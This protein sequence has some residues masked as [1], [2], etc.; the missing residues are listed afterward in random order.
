[1]GDSNISQDGL[2]S[3]ADAAAGLTETQRH[4]LIERLGGKS[5]QQIA[6]TEGKSK[7]AIAESLK[8][9]AVRRTLSIL[10][11]QMTVK[12][13]GA[14]VNLIAALLG[15]LSEIALSATKVVVVGS[16][17]RIVADNRMRLDAISKLLTL[18]DKP[19]ESDRQI[20]TTEVERSITARETHRTRTTPER[21]GGG[22]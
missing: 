14:D 4:R 20:V 9:P 2:D 19:P 1:M 16:G 5:L 21:K 10:G 11:Q 8:A 17:V 15:E 18:I 7:S 12:Q 6:T 3:I 22:Q 13:D